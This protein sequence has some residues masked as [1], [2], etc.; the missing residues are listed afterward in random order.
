MPASL[1]HNISEG[2]ACL[3]VAVKTKDENLRAA[4]ISAGISGIFGITEPALYGVTLQHKKAM[5]GVMIGGILGG[6]V[7]GLA[8]V[9]AF[10]AMGPG[11]A[12]MAMFVDP[13][14]P[15]NFVWAF[16]GFGVSLAASFIATLILYKDEA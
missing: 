7:I 2:G 14:N 8:H 9:K 3:A 16:A 15:K 1:A 12:G 6:A 13:A 11:L 4:A 10:A 5:A